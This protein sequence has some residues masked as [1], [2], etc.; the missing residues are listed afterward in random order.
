[1]DQK[2]PAI[3]SRLAKQSAIL[4]SEVERLLSQPAVQQHLD[5]SWLV[6]TKVTL[7]FGS[8]RFFLKAKEFLIHVTLPY[9]SPPYGLLQA[10]IQLK[11]SVYDVETLVQAGRAHKADEAIQ[12]EISVL[13][14]AFKRVQATKKLAKI[15][16]NEMFDS[17]GRIQDSIQTALVKAEKD[18][19]S[20]YLQRVPPFADLPPTQGAM[21]VKAT[22]PTYLD[23]QPQVRRKCGQGMLFP[24]M[25]RFLPLGQTPFGGGLPPVIQSGGLIH[26]PDYLISLLVG[27][28]ILLAHPRLQRQGPQ[29]LHRLC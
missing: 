1:M 11:A 10:H 4:Y 21:L 5:K 9:P 26:P 17:V 24:G 15:V 27:G 13:Q 28:P 22:A 3:T 7:H 6:R 14:E 25:D 16:S 12:L 8:V 2:S 18:N 20:V 23:P 29:R 19:N